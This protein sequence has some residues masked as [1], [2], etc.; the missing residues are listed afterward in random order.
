MQERVTIYNDADGKKY[1]RLAL[2]LLRF[3]PYVALIS[4]SFATSVSLTLTN[5]IEV[6]KNKDSF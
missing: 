1:V 6:V 2:F 4:Y 5:V 3:P